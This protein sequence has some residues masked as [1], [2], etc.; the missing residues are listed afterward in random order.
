[1][2]KFKHTKAKKSTLVDRFY[3]EFDASSVVVY[4]YHY[5]HPKSVTFTDDNGYFTE[6]DKWDRRTFE[7]DSNGLWCLKY[8]DEPTD[9][10]RVN[11]VPYHVVHK[12]W[13]LYNNL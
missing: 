7:L 6:S 3:Q 2:N 10:N 13:N 1:M 12:Y 9:P 4:S 11:D 5:K 8:Y